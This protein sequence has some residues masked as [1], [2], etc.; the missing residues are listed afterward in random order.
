MYLIVL[1]VSLF[2][3]LFKYYWTHSVSFSRGLVKVKVHL[4]TVEVWLCTGTFLPFHKLCG[5]L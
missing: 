4:V 2:S 5:N 3:L 1:V